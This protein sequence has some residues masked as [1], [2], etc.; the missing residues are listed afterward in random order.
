MKLI[1][2]LCL[3]F[4]IGVSCAPEKKWKTNTPPLS[5]KEKHHKQQ[6]HLL[7]I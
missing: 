2:I 1:I 7:Q 5:E 3:L 6:I 4:L